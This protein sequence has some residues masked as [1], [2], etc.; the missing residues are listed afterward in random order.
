MGLLRWTRQYAERGILSQAAVLQLL[1]TAAHPS[2]EPTNR[3]CGHLPS[4][5]D[6]R[7]E[8]SPGVSPVER[9]V[10]TRYNFG[11]SKNAAFDR[12]SAREGCD[13][14]VIRSIFRKSG[15]RFS[16]ENATTK[17]L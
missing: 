2:L 9:D 17:R 11:K 5:S 15:H 14:V 4:T 6:R 3:R 13:E 16:A 8:P 7:R 12:D 10:E 1:P